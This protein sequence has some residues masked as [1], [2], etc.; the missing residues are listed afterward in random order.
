MKPLELQK[1]TEAD[2]YILF[3]YSIRS[4]YMKESYFRRLRRFFEAISLDDKLFEVR[5]IKNWITYSGIL[6]PHS[7]NNN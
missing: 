6:F 3:E 4:P 7:T 5:T 1:E 2:P